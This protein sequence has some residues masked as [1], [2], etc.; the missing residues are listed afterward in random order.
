MH[1]WGEPPLMAEGLPKNLW[2][3]GKQ[4]DGL[5]G[6][7]TYLAFVGRVHQF[8]NTERPV[9]YEPLQDFDRTLLELL[10]TRKVNAWGDALDLSSTRVSLAL[11]VFPSIFDITD[12]FLSMPDP[13]EQSVGRHAIRLVDVEDNDTLVGLNSW[14]SWGRSPAIYV[15]RDYFDQY[16]REGLTS[17]DA[18]RGPSASTVEQLLETPDPVTFRRLW[19]AGRQRGAQTVGS[20]LLARWYETW[21]VQSEQ[22][23]EVHRISLLGQPIAWAVVH[24]DPT[25]STLEVSEFFVWPPYRKSGH[26]RPPP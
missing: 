19:R 8:G 1:A 2:Q 6:E 21:S 9:L 18:L 10:L 23:A 15:S 24:V 20:G 26:G 16:A 22:R 17:R 25:H 7:W 14:G 4:I 3:A 12:G 11:Q 5:S 13:D